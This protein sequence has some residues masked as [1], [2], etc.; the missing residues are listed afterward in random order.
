MIL[1]TLVQWAWAV[2]KRNQSRGCSGIQNEGWDALAGLA[3]DLVFSLQLQVEV[4]RSHP[5]AKLLG[6]LSELSIC[7]FSIHCACLVS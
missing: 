3:A 2:L 4:N 6:P 5:S 7:E 1:A